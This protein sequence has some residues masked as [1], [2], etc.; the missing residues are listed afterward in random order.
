M[1][2]VGCSAPVAAADRPI[3]LTCTGTFGQLSTQWIQGNVPP[4][5]AAIDLDRR[6]L[7]VLG[8]TYDIADIKETSL[9]LSGRSST[10]MV[11][12][13]SVDRT[14]GTISIS[15]MRPEEHAK[16]QKGQSAQAS[17][18]YD[19]RCAPAKERMF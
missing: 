3:L 4:T 17:M 8:G 19:L 11:F 1:M 12:F 5:S 2:L 16:L 14:A 7:Q 10:G 18:N 15:G 9:I 13:G 6:T